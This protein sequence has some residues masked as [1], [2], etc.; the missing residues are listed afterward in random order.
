MFCFSGRFV[1]V[2]KGLSAS[3]NGS[4]FTLTVANS[5]ARRMN[6]AM[7][8]IYCR[9]ASLSLNPYLVKSVPCDFFMDHEFISIFFEF[10]DGIAPTPYRVD[11]R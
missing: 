11:M 10:N 4:A 7:E 5:A 1:G 6:K 3:C 2:P 9:N 8:K